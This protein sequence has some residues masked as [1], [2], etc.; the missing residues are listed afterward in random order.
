MIWLPLIIPVLF[1][2]AALVFF[3]KRIAF[4]E[5]F[6]PIAATALIIVIFRFIGITSLTKDKEY[7]GNYVTEVRW[8]QEW[9]EWIEQT[10]TRSVPCGTDSQG[11]TT[12]CTETYDCSYRDY[13][14]QHWAMIL[15]GG[16]E[17]RIS[18]SYYNSLKRKFGT[19]SLFVDM[20]RDYY[21]IDGD[22]Y[23]NNYPN[24]Y[25]SYEFYASEHSYENKV[26]ASTSIFNYPEVTKEDITKYGLYDYPNVK[27]DM[28]SAVL[29]PKDYKVTAAEQKKFDYINGILGTSKKIRVWVCLYYCV[30]DRA[31]FM[32]EAYWKRGN[33]NELVTCIGIDR[34]GNINWVHVFGWSKNKAIEIETRNYVHDQKKLDL[35]KF[36]DWLFTEVKTKWL[37]TSF[38][39]FE[40]LSIQPPFWAVM[41]TWIVSLMACL[42]IYFWAL[43]NAFTSE[44]YNGDGRNEF[45]ENDDSRIRQSIENIKSFFV[46]ICKNIVLLWQKIF[47]NGK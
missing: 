43:T 12:Y 29:A 4:W 25:E 38:K 39:E 36:G 40:Y 14:P 45:N 21:T 16:E 22:M 15:N 7:W 37:K 3:R 18:E 2:I 32:Q 20:H 19:S 46:N 35:S 44:D 26:Q 42:G 23:S 41:V 8:Y 6:V 11:N 27:N 28:L 5:P 9:D 10:C 34:R 24:T 13:H 47:Q 1:A 17:I 30:N 33:K 31:G